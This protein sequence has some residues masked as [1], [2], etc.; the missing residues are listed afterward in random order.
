MPDNNIPQ[1]K[2]P[3][4]SPWQ[5]FL[6]T[7]NISHSPDSLLS[8][9]G[10]WWR[11]EVDEGYH[12]PS[13]HHSLGLVTGAGGHIGQSPGCLKLKIRTAEKQ[14]KSNIS[15]ITRALFQIKNGL[16]RYIDRYYKEDSH[17]TI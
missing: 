13:I 16:S 17:E 1:D 11:Q 9:V 8:H 14:C 4:Q 3:E 2:V 10:S 5:D 15:V 7:S 6:F 12:G